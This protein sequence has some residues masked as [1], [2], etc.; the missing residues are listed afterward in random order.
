MPQR[1]DDAIN[2]VLDEV[3]RN[4]GLKGVIKKA[5]QHRQAKQI[6]DQ[7]GRAYQE[8]LCTCNGNQEQVAKALYRASVEARQRGDE[9]LSGALL[10]R[11]LTLALPY[12]L[13]GDD[14]L[15]EE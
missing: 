13:Q 1:D 3:Q 15:E 11:S 2:D 8:A 14:L 12:I 9:Q 10:E 5:I 6:E 7:V 4:N